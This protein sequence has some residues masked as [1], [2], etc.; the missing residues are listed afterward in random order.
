MI[1]KPAQALTLPA[2]LVLSAHAAAQPGLLEEVVVTAQKRT[3]SLTDV[4]IS[5]GVMSAEALQKTGV[6]Q[7]REVAEFVPNLTISSGNDS[8]TAVR[9]RGVGTN[10]RNIGFDTRV[11]VY[12]D[13][14]YMGQSLAQNLDI[15]DLDRVEVVRGPQGTQFGRNT[16]AGAINMI[17]TKPTD[18]FELELLGEVGN[19]DSYRVGAIVNLP[20]SD[21]LAARVSVIDHAR[22][23]LVDNITT[24]TDHNE[25]DGTTLRGQL[26]WRGERVDVTLAADYTESDRVSFFGEAVTDWSGSV[27]TT[28]APGRFAIANNVDNYEERE[29]WGTSLNVDVALGDY[30]FT[31]ITAYRD[32]SIDRGQDT[33]H[34]SQDLLRVVYPDAYEQLTQEFQLFSPD[35]GRLKYVAGL[36]FYREE[37]TSTRRAIVGRDIGTVFQVLAPPLAPAGPL[38]ENSFAGTFGAV[39]TDSWAV[40]L[41]GTYELTDRWTLGFGARYTDEQREVDY[42]LVGSVIDL[43][44]PQ[45]PTAAVFGVAVG[46]VV[47]GLT[48][49]NFQDK[50]DFDDFSPML[51]LSYA[52]TENSNVYLKYAEGFKSGGFNVDFVSGDLLADGIDFDPETVESWELGIK[53]ESADRSLRYSVSAFYMEFEDYQLNQFIQLSNNTSAIT[54]QNAAKVVSEG[55]EAELTWYPTAAFMVQGSVGYNN[56]EFDA[57]PNGG[58]VR[59]PAGVGADLAGNKLPQAPEWSSALALQYNLPL[60]GTGG[61]LVTRVDWTYTDEYFTTEDNVSVTNPGSSIPWGKIDSYSLVNGRVGFESG[62][63]WSVYL[64]G[65]N[66]LDEDYSFDWPS[67][68]LGTSANFPGDPRTYGVEVTW[69]M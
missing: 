65:R 60:A 62:D 1:R 52:L 24:G 57:F 63:S 64:W 59:N 10:T 58:S 43:G 19:Y 32:N 39:D 68:F 11:G 49:L 3:E 6:R 40:Y 47:D 23:G 20:L 30:S 67:D 54:I 15:L 53:G 42:D 2:L 17:T 25:R 48:V 22:D 29:I 66:L 34:S 4:P 14:V 28:E 16:V 45:V 51:S 46:P 12:V 13:G 69:R 7:L 37:A 31:S 61:E 55:L 21:S 41:N 27:P 56:A 36:Y 33:D 26:A 5:I 44:G 18:E 35:T 50:Q 8:S 9:I 38:F